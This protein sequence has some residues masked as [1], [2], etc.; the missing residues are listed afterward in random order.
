MLAGF[1]WW[2]MEISPPI[3]RLDDRLTDLDHPRRGRVVINEE[4]IKG[5]EAWAP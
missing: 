3:K 5:L 2:F 1:V 4:K